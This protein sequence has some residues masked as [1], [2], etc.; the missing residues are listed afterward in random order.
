M[1]QNIYDIMIAMLRTP[2]ASGGEECVVKM[3]HDALLALVDDVYVDVLGNCIGIKK[4]GKEGGEKIVLMAHADEVGLMITAADDN[5]FLYFHEIGG[6]DTNLLPGTRVEVLGINNDRISGVIGK[7]PIHLQN[8]DEKSKNLCAEDLWIDICS[9]SKKEALD[10]IEIGTTAVFPHLPISVSNNC[11]V[12][13]GLDDKV[14]LAVLL[15]VAEQLKDINLTADIYFVASVQEELGTR[16]AKVVLEQIRPSI[17]IAIDVTHATDYPTMSPI[18]DGEIKIGGGAVIAKGPNMHKSISQELIGV[19]KSWKALYQ[20]E[21]IARPTGTDANSIQIAGC[22][23]QTGLISVPCR[24]MHT[25][26]E[27]VC[28]DDISAAI[29]VLTEYCKNK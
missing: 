27:I 21:P 15:G 11:V 12:G 4:R 20:I 22:G 18:R 1:K 16:G 26:N 10:R 23:I 6:V 5:G 19:A 9:R 7:K 24:Y 3:F 25:P 29:Q 13:S 14:G 28:L 17:G 2:S 8:R